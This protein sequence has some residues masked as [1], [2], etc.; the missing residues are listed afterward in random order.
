M[1][2]LLTNLLRITSRT[3]NIARTT[4]V[5]EHILPVHSL[6]ASMKSH[7]FFKSLSSVKDDH[8]N[9]I[10]PFFGHSIS[11]LIR[12]RFSSPFPSFD[13]YRSARR[14]K[15]EPDTSNRST[16][17]AL[18]CFCEIPEI[19]NRT[20]RLFLGAFPKRQ[21]LVKRYF[22]FS[23]AFCNASISGSSILRFSMLTSAGLQYDITLAVSNS[24]RAT[25]ANRGFFFASST[26][27]L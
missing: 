24:E 2:G 26:M 7:S 18:V 8:P 12:H 1:V 10:V 21:R 25:F 20:P 19:G 5:Q 15:K 6:M 22:A 9:R 16:H 14:L 17:I 11:S 23:A 4:R 27:C 13:F 3:T